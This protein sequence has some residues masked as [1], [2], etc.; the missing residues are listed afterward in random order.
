MKDITNGKLYSFM[1]NSVKSLT[2]GWN[3]LALFLDRL[4]LNHLTTLMSVQNSCLEISF[5]CF[6]NNNDDDYNDDNNNDNNDS[7]D[8][9]DK[10]S[11]VI[12]II[13]VY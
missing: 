10:N 9:N 5:K 11:N 2:Q 8:N 13:T 3:D 12:I 4:G 1:T 6:F 7:N